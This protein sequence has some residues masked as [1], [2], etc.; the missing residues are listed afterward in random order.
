MNTEHF[1]REFPTTAIIL[2]DNCALCYNESPLQALQM[3]LQNHEDLLPGYD[4][5]VA[6][7]CQECKNKKAPTYD[8]FRIRLLYLMDN[9]KFEIIA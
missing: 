1:L 9:Y 2:S 4:S 7:I 3:R 8:Q 5:L 6:G